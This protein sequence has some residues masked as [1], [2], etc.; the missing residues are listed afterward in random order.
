MIDP[1]GEPVREFY[2]KQGEARERE[3]IITA[4]VQRYRTHIVEVIDRGMGETY[5]S[6]DNC[7]QCV[8][9]ALIKGETKP[10]LTTAQVGQI[11][12]EMLEE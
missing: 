1:H 4:F 7:P 8:A 12:D 11:V 3:R 10:F 2:R 5:K 6:H 9:I